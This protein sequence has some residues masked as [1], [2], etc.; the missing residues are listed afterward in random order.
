LIY[1]FVL[2]DCEDLIGTISILRRLS[3][4]GVSELRRRIAERECVLEMDSEELPPFCELAERCN[5]I[6]SA[7][8]DLNAAGNVIAILEDTNG[9]EPWVPISEAVFH[10]SLE[11]MVEIEHEMD[12][13][14]ELGH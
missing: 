6:R 4:L 10:N 3:R 11:T 9:G 13:L 5:Q 7:Y 8:A 2:E 12:E 14:G 1:R